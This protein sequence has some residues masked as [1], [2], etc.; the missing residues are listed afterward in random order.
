[1]KIEKKDRH[2]RRMSDLDMRLQMELQPGLLQSKDE[3]V[4]KF[5]IPFLRFGM[6]VWKQ[7]KIWKDMGKIRRYIHP[8]RADA[9][10][11]SIFL[12]R[13]LSFSFRV[14]EEEGDVVMMWWCDDETP[15]MI[16]GDE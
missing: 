10:D 7:G 4:L 9:M 15:L 1:M 11:R 8:S 6:C 16:D 13:I 5:Q 12:Y 2:R 3:N 14:F